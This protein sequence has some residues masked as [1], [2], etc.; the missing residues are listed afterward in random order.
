MNTPIMLIKMI[1]ERTPLF[2]K[3]KDYSDL[4]YISEEAKL[5]AIAEEIL[6]FHVVGRPLLVGTTSV[7]NSEQ[8]SNRLD[9]PSIRTLVFTLMIRETWMRKHDRFSGRQADSRTCSRL[10]SLYETLKLGQPE[11][12]DQRTGSGSG[13]ECH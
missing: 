10:T 9:G 12:L 13:A 5:R 6:T 8:L 1:L 2:W 3:R 7:E 4:I 11:E